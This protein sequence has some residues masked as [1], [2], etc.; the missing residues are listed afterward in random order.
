LLQG[1]AKV[2][3]NA[4]SEQM[5]TGTWEHWLLLPRPKGDG[6]L[7]QGCSTLA[8]QLRMEPGA[9][10][11]LCSAVLPTR[12]QDKIWNTKLELSGPVRQHDRN[13][14]ILLHGNASTCAP[15]MACTMQV[16]QWVIG[17]AERN[18]PALTRVAQQHQQ[19]Q[20]VRLQKGV[21]LFV[22]KLLRGPF[23]Q[24]V[25]M[26][27]ASRLGVTNGSREEETA[28]GVKFNLPNQYAKITN[29]E[30][31]ALKYRCA[32]AE[33]TIEELGCSGKTNE[34]A[35]FIMN[36][37]SQRYIELAMA[38]L[39]GTSAVALA[40]AF[41]LLVAAWMASAFGPRETQADEQL[42]HEQIVASSPGTDALQ[43]A[44]RVG[45]ENQI[46]RLGLHI[47][48]CGAK[49]F[50]VGSD[51]GQGKL[52]I[53][54]SFFNP[55]TRKTEQHT[56]DARDSGETS[57]SVAHELNEVLS[58]Y[59]P[60][61]GL[62]QSCTDSGGGGVGASLA[63]ELA[64]H[65]IMCDQ[66]EFIV[67]FCSL[68][69]L[70]TSLR[71][72]WEK[73]LGAGGIGMMDA[74]QAAH[75]VFD[76]VKRVDW[77]S[78]WGSSQDIEVAAAALR[79]ATP[80][81]FRGPPRAVY[82][83]PPG[84]SYQ[85]RP[86]KPSKPLFTRWWTMV[87]AMVTLSKHLDEFIAW[88]TYV[89]VSQ[90]RG[91]QTTR[92]IARELISML[93]MNTIKAQLHFMRGF[94]TY[95]LK[96]FHLLQEVDDR[97]GLPG[98]HAH[99]SVLRAY[100]MQRDVTALAQHWQSDPAFAQCMGTVRSLQPGDAAHESGGLL[101]AFDNFLWES[102]A[103]IVGYTDWLRKSSNVWNAVA[104]EFPFGGVAAAAMLQKDVPLG[105]PQCSKAP[106]ALGGSAVCVRDYHAWL[107]ETAGEVQIRKS[108]LA[109]H[110]E[111]LQRLA[112][113]KHDLFSTHFSA[114]FQTLVE[115]VVYCQLS[116]TQSIENIVRKQQLHAGA[117]AAAEIVCENADLQPA[118]SD[119]SGALMLRREAGT[120]QKNGKGPA[121]TG[122]RARGGRGQEYHLGLLRQAALHSP[123]SVS[124]K[125]LDPKLA[126]RK[127]SRDASGEEQERAKHARCV[128]LTLNEAKFSATPAAQGKRKITTFGA[129][130]KE[131]LVKLLE[132]KGASAS[133]IAA[134]QSKGTVKAL[135]QLLAPHV[136][137]GFIDLECAPPKTVKKLLGPVFIGSG[138][139]TVSID[140][141]ATEDE[142]LGVLAE[143]EGVSKTR[144]SISSP[145]R[146]KQK[147]Q[148]E[149]APGEAMDET[150]GV[151][152]AEEEGGEVGEVGV[153]DVAQMGLGVCRRELQKRGIDASK[154]R[155]VGVTRRAREAL[156]EAIENIQ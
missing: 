78:T 64:Q 50:A 59:L 65:G 39:P 45:H 69:Y 15:N 90:K 21:Q 62:I 73:W 104:S 81:R 28:S 145:I 140:A 144:I 103:V 87:V 68:H 88:G 71:A 137:G 131:M 97:T 29:R 133:A 146:A 6:N 36:G 5:S 49:H 89:C 151:P 77:E 96:Y 143:F 25:G 55:K 95:F 16:P 113:C 127:R 118:R 102:R 31:G 34:G 112:Q 120:V 42:R 136:S 72:P 27:K 153:E 51:K 38:A 14:Y 114:E 110:L 130:D 30:L 125:G 128:E 134:A 107:S 60:E 111:E 150:G 119:A 79:D 2:L 9:L 116:Q 138:V 126:S 46:E 152:A 41:P 33:Q 100:G 20:Q 142:V 57:E 115:S 54:I 18:M 117:E 66:M 44:V 84:T 37:H 147:L 121:P 124:G 58:K 93:Q 149:V 85:L 70:Q 92:K 47:I 106:N 75:S 7:L 17:P 61:R 83:P 67:T 129:A 56:L 109:P 12:V 19:Q 141:S 154:W 139:R 53:A 123:A 32:R 94:S 155:G 82:K 43:R 40:N 74:V 23:D 35:T 76:V 80:P 24:W 132:S 11:L 8:L 91:Q 4:V 98:H 3:A 63:V 156:V 86:K 48:A 108:W 101:S 52:V 105:V 148:Y 22:R 135:T 13:K 1:R 26:S 10:E 122:A 99:H